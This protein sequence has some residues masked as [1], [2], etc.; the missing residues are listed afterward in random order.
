MGGSPELGVTKGAEGFINQRSALESLRRETWSRI[1]VA[2]VVFDAIFYI[3]EATTGL[4]VIACST[5]GK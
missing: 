1:D 5:G 2:E 3:R 4:L